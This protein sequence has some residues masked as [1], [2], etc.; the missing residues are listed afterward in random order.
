MLS[1]FVLSCT[2]S[3]ERSP[4]GE[5][6]NGEL[7]T[8]D[9]EG[10]AQWETFDLF[11]NAL[12]PLTSIR[13]IARQ[14]R[15]LADRYPPRVARFSENSNT[16]NR[17]TN[18]DWLSLSYSQKAE[19]VHDVAEALIRAHGLQNI[20]SPR[21]VTCKTANESDFRPQIGNTASTAKGI[22]Q[23][24]EGTVDA[25]F[26]Q[27]DFR[28]KTPGFEDVRRA[29]TFRSRMA[30]SMNAQIELGLAVFEVKRGEAGGSTNTTTILKRYRGSGSNA[31]NVDYAN[32]ILECA[33]CIRD[34]G[35]TNACLAKA[36]GAHANCE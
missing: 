33:V 21:V 13:P 16:A 10:G 8:F 9:M 29:S 22:S 20:Y 25:V 7:E 1:L 11:P 34:N 28:F 3:D 36:K 32:R 14:T 17:Y 2:G 15:T 27:T 31:C 6:A 18:A 5:L 19:H 12:A 23:V 35:L 26:L 30:R 4:A 24:T